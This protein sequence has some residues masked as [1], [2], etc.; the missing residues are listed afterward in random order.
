M[1]QQG[2]NDIIPGDLQQGQQNVAALTDYNFD[3]NPDEGIAKIVDASVEGIRDGR[4][5]VTRDPAYWW[6]TTEVHTG[7]QF[8]EA[9]DTPIRIGR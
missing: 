2:N 6:V 1:N 8:F 4:H 7:K 3:F 5:I 9:E